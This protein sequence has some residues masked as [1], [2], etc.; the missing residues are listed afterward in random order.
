MN[1]VYANPSMKNGETWTP[2]C[3]PGIREEYILYVYMHFYTQN[4]GIIMVCTDHSGDVFFECQ[5]HA[6]AM[7]REIA[8]KQLLDVIDKCTMQMFE[9]FSTFPPSQLI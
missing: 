8:D 6:E 3:I 5:K 4:F 1:Y 7:F 2:I 9:K